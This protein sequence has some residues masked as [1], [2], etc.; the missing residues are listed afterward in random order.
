VDVLLLH[1]APA[2][3]ACWAELLP[4]L[5]ARGLDGWALDLPGYGGS[6]APDRPV[7]GPGPDLDWYAD[8]V[9]EAAGGL[10]GV[11]RP[12]VL[13][14]RQTGAAVAAAVAVRHPALV[15]GLVL[16]G[17]PDFDEPLRGALADEVTPELGVD[18]E[19]AHRFVAD[20]RRH[21][22][23]ADPSQ[24]GS[25]GYVR[26]A[27]ADFLGAGLA[28]HWAHNAVGRADLGALVGAVQQPALV[29]YDRARS[30]LAAQQAATV[31]T[32]GRLPR[33][34]WVD[35]A[36]VA[37]SLDA[38]RAGALAGVVAQFVARLAGRPP[39]PPPAADANPV[40]GSHRLVQS[41]RT[42]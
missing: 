20:L 4:E 24:P 12:V 19:P 27:L 11:G 5:A 18:L 10:V 1:H 26:R 6:D 25:D 16:W 15:R 36:G 22:R 28:Q 3:S 13:V 23:R 21:D 8:R 35:L 41:R 37:S 30:D 39:D 40:H 33:G 7:D 38:G 34:E 2:S 17:Y 31:R 32:V 14:G 9:A 42:T 29:I